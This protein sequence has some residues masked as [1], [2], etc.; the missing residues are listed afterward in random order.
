MYS[1]KVKIVNL[2]EN[3]IFPSKKVENKVVRHFLGGRGITTYLGYE[4]IPVD[5]SPRGEDNNII[6]G[7]GGITGTNFPSSGTAVATFKSP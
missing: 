4:S 6:F 2:T 1:P 7:T 3:K 5:T